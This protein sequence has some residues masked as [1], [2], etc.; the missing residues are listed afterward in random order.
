MGGER[1]TRVF[2]SRAP[3]FLAPITSKR[4]LRRLPRKQ[5]KV[6]LFGLRYSGSLLHPF[7]LSFV[8]PPL[9]ACGHRHISDHRF[10]PLFSDG[11]KRGP[12]IRLCPQATPLLEV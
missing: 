9:L 10:S 4:L 7:S 2:S 11:E 1:D 5:A 8:A 3:F 6:S 12:E